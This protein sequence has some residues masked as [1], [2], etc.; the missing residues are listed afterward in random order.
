MVVLS[1]GRERKR[2]G[3]IRGAGGRSGISFGRSGLIMRR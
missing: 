3:R 1:R 2:I